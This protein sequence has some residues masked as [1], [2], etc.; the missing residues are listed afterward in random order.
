MDRLSLILL[1]K[2]CNVYKMIQIVVALVVWILHCLDQEKLL[3]QRL[4]KDAS[5]NH[6]YVNQIVI[7]V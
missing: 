3:M 5:K 1:H 4:F 2:N 7:L 6:W